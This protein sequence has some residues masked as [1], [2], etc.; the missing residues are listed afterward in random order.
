[1]NENKISEKM[2]KCVRNCVVKSV[3]FRYGGIEC[4]LFPLE[5]VFMV[6]AGKEYHACVLSSVFRVLGV[7]FMRI[8]CCFRLNVSLKNMDQITQVD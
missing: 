8:S 6:S 4:I 7:N 1:M 5:V 3:C 2:Q